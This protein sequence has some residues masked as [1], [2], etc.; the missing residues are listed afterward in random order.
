MIDRLARSITA[1]FPELRGEQLADALWLA[2]KY[3]TATESSTLDTDATATES[4]WAGR[5]EV[6]TPADNPAGTTPGADLALT[7]EERPSTE[8]QAI[9]VTEVGLR[10]PVAT[11]PT[12]TTVTALS[13]F[14]RVRRPGPP[15]VDLDATVEATADAGRL[16]VVTRPSQERGLDVAIVVDR[17]PVAMVWA[18]MIDEFAATL[19][20][21]GAFRSVSR[22]WLDELVLRDSAGTVHSTDFIIDPTGRRLVL[23][24]TDATA[25]RWYVK[26]AW[27]VLDR[28]A[29][30]MPTALVHLL[31]RSYWGYTATGQPTAT[32]RSRRPAGP[33]S[34]AEAMTSWWSDDPDPTDVP[35]PIIAL[36]Q[37]D[38]TRWAGAVVSGSAWTDAVWARPPETVATPRSELTPADRVRT[39]QS[40]ASV[41]AQD[42]ARV[43]AGAPLLSL[44]LIR[45]LHEHLVPAPETGQLAEILVSGLLEKLPEGADSANPLLRFRPGVADLLYQ[46]TTASQEWDVYEILTQHLERNASTGNAVR[47]V[48]A[49]PHGTASAEGELV[50]FAAMS[51]GVAIRLG[52]AM[53]ADEVPPDDEAPIIPL[54]PIPSRPATVPVVRGT[55]GIVC[56]PDAAPPLSAEQIADSVVRELVFGL[57]DR[58]DADAARTIEDGGVSVAWYADLFP[59][60][61]V[62]RMHMYFNDPDIRRAA[63]DR[64]S[65]MITDDIR[66][67]VAYSFG[68]VV[69]YEAL[70]AHPEWP[71]RTLVTVS[72]PLGSPSVV[73]RLD[74]PPRRLKRRRDRWPENITSWTDIAIRD[75]VE[76][77][78]YDLRDLFGG[79]IQIQLVSGM[80]PDDA[81]WH[82][83]SR[84]AASAIS[85]ALWS[86]QTTAD[87]AVRTSGGRRHLLS[88]VIDY[89]DSALMDLPRRVRE[90]AEMV[91][92]FRLLGY[93]HVPLAPGN[94]TRSRILDDLRRFVQD[95]D[96]RSDDAVML[97]LSGH[98]VVSH[99]RYFFLPADTDPN[100][101]EATGISV[102]DLDRALFAPSAIRRLL[103]VIDTDAAGHAVR[104]LSRVTGQLVHQTDIGML[105]S[106]S[107]TERTSETGFAPALVSAIQESIDRE[108]NVGDLARRITRKLPAR[109]EQQALSMWAGPRDISS[110]GYAFFS[111]PR[112]SQ[113][114][115]VE[116]ISAWRA[117]AAERRPLIVAGTPGPAINLVLSYLENISDETIS[118][119][120]RSNA[121][122][123]LELHRTFGEFT[124]KP[125]GMTVVIKDV[126]QVP[127][128]Y[129]LLPP[130]RPILEVPKFRLLF[131]THR[132]LVSQI[133]PEHIALV[134]DVESSELSNVIPQDTGQTICAFDIAGYDGVGRTRP[135]YTALRSGMYK[136]VRA[137]CV[138]SGIPWDE[139]FQQDSGD[140]I[141]LIPPVT[142][143]KDA[144]VGPLPQALATALRDHNNTHPPDEHIKLRFALHAGKVT[145]GESGVSS[146]AIV[147]AYRLIE[148]MPLQDALSK[149]PGALAMI[150]S[151]WFY[152]EVVR[153]RLQDE[154]GAYQRVTVDTK[155]ASVVGWIRLPDVREGHLDVASPAVTA[156]AAFQPSSPAFYEVVD[157]LEQLPS[158]QNERT[159]SE[160]IDRLEFAGDIRYIAPRR[161]HIISILRTCLDHESGI[162]ELMAAII[163]HE[164]ADSPAV[165][166]VFSLLTSNN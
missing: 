54:R 125:T 107:A 38:I 42:L 92:F 91:E 103:V 88:C 101:I 25:A 157:A 55:S 2:A 6:E 163:D 49:D 153:P 131:V 9:L 70:C 110:H 27:R 166:R 148:T 48:L 137:A 33:N 95:S 3:S 26:Q 63:R 127:D 30:A 164:P 10:V 160:V 15:V 139:S 159:R 11:G 98:A 134:V 121:E 142:V 81:G 132:D 66:V 52:I 72:A 158:M 47:A 32:V 21:T 129:R 57:L 60:D 35:I 18:D 78:G 94:Q 106:T 16:V 43:L 80:R 4:A 44:P 135:N 126:D 114:R 13:Q 97:Y 138:E 161:A 36:C 130:L 116:L 93:E 20:R 111:Q 77:V 105:A 65:A 69:A 14:R 79:K 119:A 122:I 7:D 29:K 108:P 124:A 17:T 146:P 165:E 128:S 68:A 120:G 154:S 12:P 109:F 123:A 45:V 37:E 22:W 162:D 150:L 76:A 50:P 53:P 34:G 99:G 71:V 147:H 62:E 136:S 89:S 46:G 87:A 141:L 75:D 84:K 8:S 151:D 100:Q 115:A 149:S 156:V 1:A 104:Q 133:D 56:V 41:G 96:R 102:D 145:L 86:S 67:I 85:K 59:P 61:N 24:L 31:P 19:R 118:A 144:F 83:G 58:G 113:N 90:A 51:R 155:E 28:W 73:D 39:F 82:L 140:G 112:S 117:D 64:L 74:P 143:P 152:N 40:R 23:L 5:E